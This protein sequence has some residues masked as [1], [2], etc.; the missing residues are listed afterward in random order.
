MYQARN[1]GWFGWFA[2]TTPRNH[3]V[4]FSDLC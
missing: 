3:R 4:Q 1:Q 2:R